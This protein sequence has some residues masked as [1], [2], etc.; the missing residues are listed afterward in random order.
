MVPTTSAGSRSGVNWMREKLMRRHSATVRTASVFARPGTPPSRMCPPVSSPIISRSTMTSW[1]TTRLATS[2]VMV[3]VSAA[4]WVF[5]ALAVIGATPQPPVSP[6]ALCPA[7]R[8][9]ATP[10]PPNGPVAPG[11][12]SPLHARTAC[13]AVCRPARRTWPARR[14]PLWRRAGRWSSA[15]QPIPPRLSPAPAAGS[16]RST[17][18]RRRRRRSRARR[19]CAPAPIR[20]SVRAS[21][22]AI[23]RAHPAPRVRA[24]PPPPHLRESEQARLAHTFVAVPRQTNQRF[25]DSGIAREA[26]ELRRGGHDFRHLALGFDHQ[27]F[28]AA[29]AGLPH[30]RAI[31]LAQ[32]G[33]RVEIRVHHQFRRTR[34][35]RADRADEVGALSRR[36]PLLAETHDHTLHDSLVRKRPRNLA[37]RVLN[38]RVLYLARAAVQ[39]CNNFGYRPDLAQR[40]DVGR[41]LPELLDDLALIFRPRRE[42]QRLRG[43]ARFDVRRKRLR[44]KRAAMI[45]RRERRL[46]GS[47]GD[48]W[49]RCWSNR[50]WRCWSDRWWRW[51]RF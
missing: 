17:L 2:R 50:W 38:V 27:H 26:Q 11:L 7:R 29:I 22:V 23:S 10:S 40:N 36:Y 49:G 25:S 3:C 33:R 4:S 45:R 18:P 31:R 20:P 48:C 42:L 32:L 24:M 46:R 41:Q 43:P 12:R 34:A 9:R 35:E 47:S 15:T 37:D 1:P 6:S 5:A 16:G 8:V 19:P 39:S 28:D 51:W 44:A 21:R 30:R 13:A 14:A